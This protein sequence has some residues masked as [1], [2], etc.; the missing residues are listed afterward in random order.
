MYT[1]QARSLPAEERGTAVNPRGGGTEKPDGDVAVMEGQRLAEV[2][3]CGVD[4]SR[5]SSKVAVG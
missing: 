1:H 5:I 2:A 3:A 4:T